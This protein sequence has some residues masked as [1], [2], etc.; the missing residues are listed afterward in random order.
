[1]ATNGQDESPVLPE[2]AEAD[3][4]K[5]TLNQQIDALQSRLAQIEAELAAT[6]PASS[7]VATQAAPLLVFTCLLAVA[8][9]ALVV[10]DR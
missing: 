4:E 8:P 2:P 3:A 5:A 1:M 10:M 9:P 6:R 7:R